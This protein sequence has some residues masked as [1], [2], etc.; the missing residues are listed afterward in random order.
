M[1]TS[2]LS[3]FSVTLI[4]LLSG[5]LDEPQ[6]S[7]F[8]GTELNPPVETP[9][10]QLINQYNNSVNLTTFTGNVIVVSFIFTHCTDTC[11]PTTNLLKNLSILLN[12]NFESNVTFLS[13]STD[14]YRDTPEML[15]FFTSQNNV[16]WPHLSGSRDSL[17]PVWD[18]FGVWVVPENSDSR[19]N[20]THPNEDYNVLHNSVVF[21]L[22]KDLRKRSL[23]TGVDWSPTYLLHDIEILLQE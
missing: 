17:K 6:D 9:D 1:N 19:H 14:P 16:S 18:D 23:F 2:H 8:W 22:D 15:A 13:I 3:I 20:D 7:G 11:L 5:C 21:I 4:V 10:F 12:S